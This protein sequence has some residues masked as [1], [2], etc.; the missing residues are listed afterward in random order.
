[1]KSVIGLLISVAASDSKISE[2]EN[3]LIQLIGRVNNISREEIDR[4]LQN[5]GSAGNLNAISPEE[6]FEVI[7]LM[8]Q[9]MKVDG[10]IFKSEISTCEKIASK[11]GY[12]PQVIQELSAGIFSDPTITSDRTRLMAKANRYLGKS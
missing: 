7:Y 5:P 11:L 2:E 8:I 3:K 10:Q 6:K 4:L 12:H 9:L 1:V